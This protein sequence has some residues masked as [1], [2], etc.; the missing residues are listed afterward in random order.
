M[1]LTDGLVSYWKLE[2]AS[3]TRTDEHG[4]NDLADINTVTST[5]GKLGDCAS[6][7]AANSERLQDL[8]FSIS[9]TEALS[10]SLWM[11]STS[12]SNV[13]GLIALTPASTGTRNDVF[14]RVNADTASPGVRWV[15]G[16]NYSLEPAAFT[17]TNNDDGLWHHYV[18]KLYNDTVGTLEL[19]YDGV[20]VGS[21]SHASR[22]FAFPTFTKLYVG[23]HVNN[24]NGNITPYLTGQI[25]ELAIWDRA[26]T[27]DEV[28]SLYNG[29]AGLA[30]PLTTTS[31]FIPR[32]QWLT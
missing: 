25:D 9:D 5:T 22:A 23:V 10:F 32:S 24:F 2:E 1:A 8:T 12:L 18:Y 11:K 19:Y 3:G 15:D 14:F 26:I 27:S 13:P 7:A 6:F 17:T 29:G 28:T 20:S 31:A 16:A 21:A 30:Y 4:G